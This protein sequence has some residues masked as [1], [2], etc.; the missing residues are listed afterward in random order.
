MRLFS[1]LVEYTFTEA[2]ELRIEAID[3]AMSKPRH[4]LQ[5]FLIN[6]LRL[7]MLKTVSKT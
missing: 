7:D 1:T 6:F 5:E 4:E 2:Q 3:P